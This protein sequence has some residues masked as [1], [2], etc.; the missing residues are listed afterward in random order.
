MEFFKNSLENLDQHI[1]VLIEKEGISGQHTEMLAE[2]RKA[3]RPYDFCFNNCFMNANFVDA[4][5]KLTPLDYQIKE[6][7]NFVED[8]NPWNEEIGLLKIMLNNQDSIQ[9]GEPQFQN[10]GLQNVKM[11]GNE[12]SE[13]FLSLGRDLG[14]LRKELVTESSSETI[15]SYDFETDNLAVLTSTAEDNPSFG[16]V[17]DTDELLQKKE[18]ETIMSHV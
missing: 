1:D 3:L 16:V 11:Q 8:F 7:E 2:E 9:E 13:D 14:L 15:G 4:E 17:S 12:D 6:E 10:W 5:E 18:G